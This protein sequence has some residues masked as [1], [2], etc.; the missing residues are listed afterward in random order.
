M[1]GLCPAPEHALRQSGQ[2]VIGFLDV[3]ER[4]DIS[5]PPGRTDD[6]QDRQVSQ[7]GRKPA[8]SACPVCGKTCAT[9]D[10]NHAGFVREATHWSAVTKLVRCFASAPCDCTAARDKKSVNAVTEW[11][12]TPLPAVKHGRYDSHTQG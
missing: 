9:H 2:R 7:E 5:C 12:D 4:R 10:F 8:I 3:L 6:T 1:G 11:D